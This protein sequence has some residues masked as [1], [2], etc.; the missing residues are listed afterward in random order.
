MLILD[1]H[2]QLVYSRLIC[3]I[4]L[5]SGAYKMEKSPMLEWNKRKSATRR[6]SIVY[7]QCRCIE[8]KQQQYIFF[9]LHFI[10]TTSYTINSSCMIFI[11]RFHCYCC[12]YP[13]CMYVCMYVRCCLFRL[14]SNGNFFFSFSLSNFNTV[15]VFFFF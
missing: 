12:R 8:P 1:Y 3:C 6:R 7:T 15:Q 10:S 11:S 13:V 5:M 4:H 9:F 2:Q 14:R